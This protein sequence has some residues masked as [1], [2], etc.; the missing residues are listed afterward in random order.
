MP[1]LP[2]LEALRRYLA[3]RLPGK[4]IGQVVVNRKEC[5]NAPP[6]K[7]AQVL[8]GATF[9]AVW[10]KA[11]TVICD[12]SNEISILVHLALGGDVVLRDTREH[13]PDTAQIVF[14]FRDGSALHFENLQLG[15]VHAVP[16]YRIGE[17]RIG[18]LGPDA[19]DELPDVDG[20]QAL[21]GTKG[22]MM[23]PLLCNQALLSGLGNTWAD[24]ILFRARINPQTQAKALSKAD[25]E[26]LHQSMR[27]CIR[28]GIEAEK[29]RL[30]G[31]DG[32][33]LQIHG[34]EG[35]PC[36]VCGSTIKKIKVGGSGT[37]LCGKCQRKKSVRKKS[38]A[39]K[40]AK[41]RKSTRKKGR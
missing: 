23:K 19:L 12:L 30:A 16:T 2:E 8:A 20:L 9:T 22:A 14:A 29:A 31:E 41:K 7:Y 3:P 5:I 33:E 17:T 18:K 36:P 15:N 35:E 4:T 38:A 11:K 10:R 1:E 27:E 32:L 37:F 26:R 24:E 13:D 39:K 25:F 21:Y 6:A 40:K 34:R 28:I